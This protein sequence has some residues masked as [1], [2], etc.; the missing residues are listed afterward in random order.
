MTSTTALPES[1]KTILDELLPEFPK[2]ASVVAHESYW[3]TREKYY[4]RMSDALSQAYEAKVVEERERI[5][6]RLH[7]GFA[8]TTARNYPSWDGAEGVNVGLIPKEEVIEFI[9][10]LTQQKEGA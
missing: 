10:S 7:R 1:I 5:L 9:E 8:K 6:E 4:Q 3:R 2:V